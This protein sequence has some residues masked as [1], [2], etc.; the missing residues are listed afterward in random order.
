MRIDDGERL[1][2]LLQVLDDRNESH[3]LDNVGKIAGMEGMAIV[4][5][6]CVNLREPSVHMNDTERHDPARC[7]IADLKA[8]LEA[9]R[10]SS[11]E[12]VAFYLDRIAKIDR[13]GPMLNSVIVV[14][15]NAHADA[16]ER[17]AERQRDSLR[18]PLHGIPIL[19]KDN[20]ETS[21][22]TPTTA[23]SLALKDNLAN[24]DAPCAARLRAAGAIII[25]K[26]NLSEWANIRSNR[27]VSG[28]SALGGLV[29]NPH[30]LDR[31]C[32]GSSSGSAAA[33]AAGFAA[34]A[35]GTETDGSIV[36]PSDVCGIVGL[37][38]TVGLV[39]R[40]HV[41]PISSSQDTPGP[42]T[43]SIA[44]TALLLSAMTGR[45]P[46][47]RATASADRRRANYMAGLSENTLSG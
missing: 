32:S 34:A 29:R 20:I 23:G 42:M 26:A 19:I 47:D 31:S 38:P 21:D 4:H 13:A 43:R 27:S 10:A 28:W 5:G 37:K 14:N 8:D 1:F 24:R 7:A 9:N 3:M 36:S 25:G 41:V 39:S 12:L 30:V 17:D 44:D 18:G 46:A 40:T 45:D 2:L 6:V 11:V 22:P 33:I 16:A 35:I 15:P